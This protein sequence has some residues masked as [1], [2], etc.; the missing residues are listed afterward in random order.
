M[1]D[2]LYYDIAVDPAQP[3]S[4][5]TALAVLRRSDEHNRRMLEVLEFVTRH[6]DA[7]ALVALGMLIPA[8][9][10]EPP[11]YPKPVPRGLWSGGRKLRAA[12]PGIVGLEPPTLHG[13]P[14]TRSPVAARWFVA[15]PSWSGT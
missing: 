9:A 4:E 6:A 8:K 3:G 5:K 10:P 14:L 13:C 2:S 11:P 7:A 12:E 15:P 1:F